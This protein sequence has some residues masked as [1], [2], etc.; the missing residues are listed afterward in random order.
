MYQDDDTS[1]V[2]SGGDVNFR[3]CVLIVEKKETQDQTRL[4]GP[5][6]LHLYSQIKH[7]KKYSE[8]L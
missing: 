1:G 7:K 8:F 6:I 4:T 5:T 2:L 3:P